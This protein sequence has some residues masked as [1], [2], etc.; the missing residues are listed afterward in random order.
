MKTIRILT[1]SFTLSLLSACGG[2]SQKSNEE[3]VIEEPEMCGTHTLTSS[4]TCVSVDD[5]DAVAFYPA[6]QPRGIAI[7][8]HGAPGHPTKVMNIFG[9]KSITE[10]YQYISIAPFGSDAFWGWDS[11]VTSNTADMSLDSNYL[12][13]L[14][15]H[16][17]AN[18]Q[19]S[20]L[21]VMVFG[22]SAGG[23]MNYRLACEIPE[24]ISAFV[25]L[26][27][28]FRGNLE[29]CSTTTA[30]RIHHLHSTTDT[31]V[32]Y[33]GR[34]MGGIESVVNTVRHWQSINGCQG[35]AVEITEVG[36]TADSS[37]TTTEIAQGCTKSVRLSI[38]DDV[39]HEDSY[40]SA[41][42]LQIVS[43]LFDEE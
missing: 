22:Y 20:A 4:E 23:F 27:G 25:S 18:E 40:V 26:A 11:N 14:I 31:D 37:G 35:D 7:F 5:R 1:I 13:S 21:P 2:G 19:L 17:E 36:L 3:V 6:Q 33:A 41:N 29:A 9:A 34:Q 38:F 10:Q 43:Y 8:L 15:S 39:E 24:Q 12:Q 30:T 42:I 32:P 28:Q 16:I